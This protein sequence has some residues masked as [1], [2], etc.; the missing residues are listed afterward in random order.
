[1]S[2]YVR[3][4]R[5]LLGHPAFRNDAEAMAFAWL[6]A[7][8]A[9]QP[10][11]QRYKGRDYAFERGQLSISIR[12]F[13]DKQD[14]SKGWVERLFARLVEYGMIAKKSGTQVGTQVGTHGGTVGGTPPDLITICNYE[15]YQARG[16]RRETLDETSGETSAGHG[17]DTEQVREEV[18]KDNIPP[19]AP[20]KRGDGVKSLIPSDWKVP[21]VSALPPKARACAEQWTPESYD[22]EAE[23]FVCYWR[24]ERK[25]K[26][27]WNA[28]WANRIVQRHSAIMRDQKFGNAAPGSNRIADADQVRANRLR[29]IEIYE[30]QGR[31]NEAEELRRQIAA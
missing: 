10:T 15:E 27:D 12:D 28:T 26:G 4:H 8:A 25:M 29:L 22:T 6:V 24:S 5:S 31:T 2:G 30:Q 16:L 23:A 20:R 19:V 9:W 11:T 13:A 3:I 18:K 17:R 7:K 21:L 1:V 14:R